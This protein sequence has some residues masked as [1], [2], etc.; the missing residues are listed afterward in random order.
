MGGLFGEHPGWTVNAVTPER[1]LILDQWGTFALEPAAD[2]RTRFI[3]RSTMSNRQIPVW[4][5]ALNL[6][7]FQ[8][9]HYIMQRR[10]M[11]T[12]KELAEER[13]AERRQHVTN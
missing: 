13:Y 10:M 5:S 11:L 12:I 9:P 7:A 8:M 6:F 4:A 3:I 2:Q 1:T